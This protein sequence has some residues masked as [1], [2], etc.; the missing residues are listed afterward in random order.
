M[1][2]WQ[3]ED[4]QEIITSYAPTVDDHGPLAGP[5]R[6]FKIRRDADLQ[7]CMDTEGSESVVGQQTRYLPGTVR[8]NEDRVTFRS[9]MGLELEAIGVS[10]SH[11]N[12]HIEGSAPGITTQNV[13]IQR[14]VG[15]FALPRTP[16]YTIDW[17]ENFPSAF[18][19][20]DNIERKTE[21]TNTVTL[22]GV[23]P[24]RPKLVMSGSSSPARSSWAAAQLEVDGIRLYLCEAQGLDTTDV[25]KPG[26]IVYD[27]VPADEFRDR[28]RRGLSFALGSYLVYLGVSHFDAEWRLTDFEV[29]SPYTMHGHA[30]EL[31][32]T[33]PSPLGPRSFWDIEPEKLSRMVNAIYAKYDE[34]NFGV[35][36]WAYWHAVTAAPHIAAVHFGAALESLQRAYFSRTEV[37]RSSKILDDE[38]WSKVQAPLE[39]VL[40]NSDLTN[41]TRETLRNKIKNL[42]S[43]S[44]HSTSKDLVDELGLALSKREKEAHDARHESAHGKDSEV[45][46]EWIRDLKLLRIRFHRIFLA[47]T[48]ANDE[49]YDYFTLGNPIRRVKEPVSDSVTANRR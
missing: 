49:Y 23:P 31:P 20:P 35:V 4:F 18:L 43:R 10:V 34:L 12:T 21:K 22:G 1:F 39:S 48:E 16:R 19:W 9:D 29:V 15:K 14:L 40:D 47:M 28:L 37:P 46:V 33:P 27:G 6:R 17:L 38:T 41:D 30:T 26:F 2:S 44:Q 7:V 36:S 13:D 45:D 32:P 25:K 11:T 3:W 8:I 42:N 5:V 24:T